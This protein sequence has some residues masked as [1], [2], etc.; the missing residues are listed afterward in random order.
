MLHYFLIGSGFAFA[1]ALQPGPLQAFLFSSAVRHGWKR[2]LPASLSP[3]LSDGP[4]A[5]FVLLILARIPETFGSVLQMGG[6]IFLIYLAW[7]ASKQRRRESVTRPG[8]LDSPP[9]TLIQAAVVNVLNPNPYLGWSLVLGPAA[10]EAWH[11]G[12]A[13]AGVLIIAFYATMVAILAGSIVLFATSRL[14]GPRGKSSLMFASEF[15]LAALGL[16]LI[17]SSLMRFHT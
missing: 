4:I 11:I 12:P 17:G 2:T 3:L 15:I 7:D 6:G 16:Y 8:V 1:A 13:H 5:V 14:L 10:L 9:R